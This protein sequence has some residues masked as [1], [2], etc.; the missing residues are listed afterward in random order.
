MK[1]NPN[2][3]TV[4]S[5]DKVVADIG[6][7]NTLPREIRAEIRDADLLWSHGFQEM[8]GSRDRVALFSMGGYW[9]KN[10]RGRTAEYQRGKGQ[11]TATS[12]GSKRWQWD[13]RVLRQLQQPC[14][15]CGHLLPPT[16]GHT[17][18]VSP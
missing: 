7:F 17:T 14:P 10:R 2:S 3:I 6:N 18:A 16:G 4:I 9:R 12:Y 1:Y 8:V 11:F 5:F 15:N 13:G